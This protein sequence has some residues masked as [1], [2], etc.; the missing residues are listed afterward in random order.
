MEP[1]VW[2]EPRVVIEVLADEIIRSP[3]HPAGRANVGS[4][5]TP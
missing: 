1:S 3:T 4:L 2:V 5:V